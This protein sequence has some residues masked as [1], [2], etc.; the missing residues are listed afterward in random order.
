[1]FLSLGALHIGNVESSSTMSKLQPTPS[2]EAFLQRIDEALQPHLRHNAQ[3]QYR[4]AVH[5]VFNPSSPLYPG[6]DELVKS[7]V[8]TPEK[9]WSTDWFMNLLLATRFPLATSNK[10]TILLN[11]PDLTG[12]G[13]MDIAAELLHA[14]AVWAIRPVELYTE[15][16]F[17]LKAQLEALLGTWR[18]PGRQKDTLKTP[19]RGD[20]KHVI[21]WSGGRAWKVAI[22]TSNGV[23]L[24]V[25]MLV[26]Q[27]HLISLKPIVGSYL[28]LPADA[29][30]FQE[31]YSIP[32]AAYSCRLNRSDWAEMFEKICTLVETQTLSTELRRL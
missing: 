4:Q 25:P 23:P 3:E 19:Q 21:V 31:D 26:Q 22:Y 17:A 5:T 13:Q 16:Q 30:H 10:L 8:S 28:P 1:M 14:L 11:L 6:I 27:L 24:P 32:L 15:V 29:E 9:N 20:A 12:R 7:L 2:L 18:T